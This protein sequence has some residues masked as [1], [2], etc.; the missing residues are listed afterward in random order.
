[1]VKNLIPWRKKKHEVEV[2]RPEQDDPTYDLT[3]GMADM[4]DHFFRRFDADFGGSLLR[5]DFASSATPRLDIAETGEEVTVTADLPGLD[6]KD[7]Q[8]SL[9]GD[10][11]TLRGE[12]R[13]EHEDKRKNYHRI[14]RSYGSFVRTVALPEGIDRDNVK[15]SFKKGVLTVTIGKT[16]GAKPSRRRIPVQTG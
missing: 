7:I 4:M 12:R 10:L 3:R 9:D 11:L 15:A 2:L 5:G 13:H 8:V 6:E 14:E 16:P 1:M